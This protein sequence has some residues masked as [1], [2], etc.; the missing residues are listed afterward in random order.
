[1]KI[2]VKK[3]IA[4]MPS[5]NGFKLQKKPYARKQRSQT[6]KK[7]LDSTDMHLPKDIAERMSIASTR[8]E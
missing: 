1:M 2:D 5:G 3:M 4:I 8:S 6:S 7:Y